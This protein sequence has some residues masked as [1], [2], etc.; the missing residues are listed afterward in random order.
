VL[1]TTLET[2]VIIAGVLH[3]AADVDNHLLNSH[4]FEATE[5]IPELDKAPNI[6]LIETIV[7]PVVGKL[8][9]SRSVMMGVSRESAAVILELANP[10][11]VTRI[12]TVAR[13]SML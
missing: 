13:D 6:P 12:E 11:D 4:R 5:M 9:L 8:V 10:P 3:V 7:A 1:T 2:K